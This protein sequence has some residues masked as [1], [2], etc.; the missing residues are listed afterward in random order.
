MELD[1]TPFAPKVE[2][3]ESVYEDAPMPPRSDSLSERGSFNEP[4]P[5]PKKIERKCPIVVDV[6]VVLVQLGLAVLLGFFSYYYP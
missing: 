6:I 1:T 2:R 3:S 4:P 5:K